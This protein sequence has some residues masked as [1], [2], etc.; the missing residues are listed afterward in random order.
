MT[1]DCGRWRPAISGSD[2]WDA[3]QATTRRSEGTVVK[4]HGRTS[5]SGD[6]FMWCGD[7]PPWHE[8][9]GDYRPYTDAEKLAGRLLTPP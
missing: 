7:V 6:A 2:Y 4:F 1:F 9:L 5:G 3:C 8:S